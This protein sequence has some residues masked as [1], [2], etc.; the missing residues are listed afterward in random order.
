MK[1]IKSIKNIVSKKKVYDDLGAPKES[2]IEKEIEKIR[3]KKSLV[4]SVEVSQFAE[5]FQKGASKET[6]K[7]VI[8]CAN[9][10]INS[11]GIFGHYAFFTKELWRKVKGFEDED[12]GQIIAVFLHWWFRYEY[13]YQDMP[14]GCGWSNDYPT[15]YN[16]YDECYNNY[17][18]KYR[19]VIEAYYDWCYRQR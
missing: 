19:P 7:E 13:G 11:A 9:W 1:L 5:N 17:I 3:N 16:E 10:F 2:Y 12:K 14:I 18:E 8:R 6:K 4:E 15:P